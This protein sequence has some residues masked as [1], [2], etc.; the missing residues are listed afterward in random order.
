MTETIWSD[1]RDCKVADLSVVLAVETI[2]AEITAYNGRSPW[3]V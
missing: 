2:T 1:P 3:K